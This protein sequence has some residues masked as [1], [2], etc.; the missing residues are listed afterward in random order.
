VTNDDGSLVG[1]HIRS[2][3]TCKESLERMVV[4]VKITTVL[5]SIAASSDTVEFE[6]RQMKHCSNN[7]H[8]KGKKSKKSPFTYRASI[9]FFAIKCMCF[10][11]QVGTTGF[12]HPVYLVQ[13]YWNQNQ[14]MPAGDQTEIGEN[15]LNLSGGQKMRVAL[16]RAVYAQVKRY[17]RVLGNFIRKCKTL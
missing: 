11:E 6:G 14:E 17:D 9:L 7:V 16:A 5:G 10:I 8:N 4:N 13:K 15:G 3:S 2:N 12:K 1:A